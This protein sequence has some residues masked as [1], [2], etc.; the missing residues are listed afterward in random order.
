MGLIEEIQQARAGPAPYRS[1]GAE[2]RQ[3]FCHLQPIRGDASWR[4][5]P[6]PGRSAA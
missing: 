4:G 2:L 1:F 6:L 3:H 5:S